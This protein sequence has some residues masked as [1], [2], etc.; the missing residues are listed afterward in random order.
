MV[1]T[2]AERDEYLAALREQVC[3]CCIERRANCPPCGPEKPCGVEAHLEKIVQMCRMVESNQMA[4]YIDLMH[5]LICPNCEFRDTAACPCPLDYL[6][7]PVLEAAE[8]VRL[9]PV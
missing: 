9:C 5:E 7:Q 8:S 6:L 2:E 4:V 3:S 1:L